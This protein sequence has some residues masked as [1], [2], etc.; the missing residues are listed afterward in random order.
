MPDTVNVHVLWFPEPSVPVRVT[1]VTV[2][3]ANPPAGV[4]DCV[5]S[6]EPQ[7]S[8]ETACPV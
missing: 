5:T 6:T 8:F 2:A 7:A 1:V 3:N 4:G